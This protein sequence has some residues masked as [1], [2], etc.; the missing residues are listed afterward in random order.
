M[1]K[2]AKSRQE[3]TLWVRGKK[4]DGNQGWVNAGCRLIPRCQPLASILGGLHPPRLLDAL[5]L[6]FGTSKHRAARIQRFRARNR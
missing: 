2:Q 3:A 1:G 4:W 5:K 6:R